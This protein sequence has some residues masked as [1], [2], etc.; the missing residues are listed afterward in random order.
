MLGHALIFDGLDA[1]ADIEMLE[2]QAFNNAFSEAGLPWLWD[3]QTCHAFRSI[4]DGAERIRLYA[5]DAGVSMTRMDVDR[6]HRAVIR[7]FTARAARFG[8]PLRPGVEQAIDRA[9]KND[10]KIGLVSRH[11]LAPAVRL[12]NAPGISI[13]ALGPDVAAVARVL[14]T[15][16]MQVVRRDDPLRLTEA[17]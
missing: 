4:E 1:L 13:D 6:L 9:R 2:C 11:I 10:S 15:V 3:A 8:V 17:A 14:D 16:E 5:A 7:H 12:Y